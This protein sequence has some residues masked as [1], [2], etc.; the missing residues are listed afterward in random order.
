MNKTLI[1]NK[2][3]N[4]YLSSRDYN[5][6]SL[7][8]LYNSFSINNNYMLKGLNELIKEK[9][10]SLN[11]DFPH[12]NPFIKAFKPLPITKQIDIL[13]SPKEYLCFYPTKKSLE[14]KVKSDDF[15]DRPFTYL[16]KIGEPQ[17][18]FL[19]FDLSILE[20]YK[21]DPRYHYKNDDIAGTIY[22]NE[23]DNKRNELGE[24]DNI[25]I[26]TFGFSYN[27]SFERAVCVYLRYL[28]QLNSN[29]QVMWDLKKLDGNF[30]IHPDY[31][32]QTM[33]SWD[34][35]VSIFSAFLEEQKQIN[36]MCE[37]IGLPNLFRTIFDSYSKPKDFGFLLRP[38]LK[39]FN[40]FILI[41]DKLISENI[42]NKFF[43]NNILPLTLLE[44]DKGTIQKLE[45]W[46]KINYKVKNNELYRKI[47]TP[48]FNV[49]NLRQKPA[50]K[51][52]DDKFDQNYFKKQRKIIIDVHGSMQLL[53]MA[54]ARHPKCKDYC[55]PDWLK[56][57]NITDY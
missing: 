30:K 14:K 50:H 11:T 5:G 54:F 20:Y 55:I 13:S 19:S 39:E 26:D 44:K 48:F 45:R 43:N 3:T 28:S 52:E 38:T 9:K 27:Q 42:N 4:F 33:G 8:D 31:F 37:I 12:P 56:K 7:G 17:F 29:H 51:I 57:G 32:K 15:H 2:I 21:N 53:R 49:R 36:K 25:F 1:L 24:K 40:N 10:I 18:K 23:S 34:T 22:V 46:L 47:M 35:N 16:L 41:L 6:I